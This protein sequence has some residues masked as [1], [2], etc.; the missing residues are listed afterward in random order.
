MRGFLKRSPFLFVFWLP[1]KSFYGRRTLNLAV[2]PPWAGPLYRIM[3]SL[4]TSVPSHSLGI[5]LWT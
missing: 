2:N 5:F 4:E 1:D 3:G